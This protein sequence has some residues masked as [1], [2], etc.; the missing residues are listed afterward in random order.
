MKSILQTLFFVGVTSAASWD[1]KTNGKDWPQFDSTDNECGTGTN[2]SPI[3]L[4]TSGW[5]LKHSNFDNFNKMY[6]DQEVEVEVKWNG[7]TSQVE[8]SKEG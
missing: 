4:R 5:P 8:I 3:D 2:Q 6:T 1:Y 7:H